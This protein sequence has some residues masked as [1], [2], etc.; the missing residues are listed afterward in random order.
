M[1]GARGAG[2]FPVLLVRPW[3]RSDPPHVPF[4][5]Y[6]QAGSFKIDQFWEGGFMFCAD[7]GCSLCTLQIIIKIYSDP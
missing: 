2:R 5:L 1:N 4:D 6:V 3:K 7:Q